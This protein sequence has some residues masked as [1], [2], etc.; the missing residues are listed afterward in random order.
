MRHQ[1]PVS[2]NNFYLVCLFFLFHF[3]FFLFRNHFVCLPTVVVAQHRHVFRFFVAL[4]IYTF[5]WSLPLSVCVCVKM[6]FPME[7]Y[8]KRYPHFSQSS[9]MIFFFTAKFS[10]EISNRITIYNC[11][12]QLCAVHFLLA[13]LCPSLL[14]LLIRL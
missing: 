9:I 12:T 7:C 1:I 6:H 3:F 5:P 11:C 8:V 2:R 13:Q 10:F 4:Q 14:T